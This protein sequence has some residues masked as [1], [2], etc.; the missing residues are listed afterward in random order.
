M[1]TW[2]YAH[3]IAVGFWAR[4]E[5]YR[6]PQGVG[7]TFVLA[8]EGVISRQFIEYP[9]L[10]E[11]NQRIREGESLDPCQYLEGSEFAREAIDSHLDGMEGVIF[12]AQNRLG[13]LNKAGSVGWEYIGGPD[14]NLMRLRMD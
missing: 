7:G 12:H 5:G 9:I 14:E 1:A 6:E 3:I 11:I 8:E 2:K 4:I 10:E 13:L